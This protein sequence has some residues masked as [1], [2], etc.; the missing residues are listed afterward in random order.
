MWLPVTVALSACGC[1]RFSSLSTAALK[2]ANI[3]RSNETKFLREDCDVL[4]LF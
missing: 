3:E 1:K 2:I 4:V